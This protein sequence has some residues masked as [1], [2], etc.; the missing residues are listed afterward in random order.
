VILCDSLESQ[1]SRLNLQF[2]K[3]RDMFII[4]LGVG[5]ASGIKSSKFETIIHLLVLL[6]HIF[7]EKSFCVVK[8]DCIVGS[9]D[10]GL[11]YSLQILELWNGFLIILER[12]IENSELLKF[13]S[14]KKFLKR[15]QMLLKLIIIL[16]HSRIISVNRLGR[17]E[18]GRLFRNIVE[19]SNEAQEWLHL[20]TGS[21]IQISIETNKCSPTFFNICNQFDR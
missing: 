8:D 19:I 7:R 13:P 12:F 3:Q 4:I 6:G 14:L 21:T 18:T 17:L 10:E 2:K 16:R 9:E 15:F 1:L 5:H 11:G 20:F